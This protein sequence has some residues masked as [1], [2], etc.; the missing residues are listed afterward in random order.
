MAYKN[1][2]TKKPVIVSSIATR[3]IL[4][5]NF[6]AGNTIVWEHNSFWL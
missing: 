2:H 6:L 1:T 4:K 3:D 5:E